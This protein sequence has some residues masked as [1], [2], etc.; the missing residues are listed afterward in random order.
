MSI[1]FHEK[2]KT[3]HLTNGQ[4]SYIFKVVKSGE[5]GQLYFGKALRDRE[6][7]DTLLEFASRS[8][9]V[10]PYDE[11]MSYSRDYI[12]QEYPC[13][14]TGDMQYPAFEIKQEN[15]SHI[16]NF[17]YKEHKIYA[18]KPSL[19][20]LPATYVEDDSEAT[21]IEITLEDEVINTEIILTYTIYE[22]LPVIA[23]NTKF[24]HKGEESIVLDRAMSMSLDLP[25]MDY[26]MI[27]LTGAWARERHIKTR[28]LDHGVTSIY[29]LRGCSSHNYNPFLALK[30]ENTTE[31]SGEV[32]GMSLVYSGNFLAQVDVD[33]YDVTRWMIGIHPDGFSWKLN[34]GESFQTPEAVLVYSNEGLNGMSQTFHTLYRS[35]LAKGEWR[36]KARPILIN[37]WEGTYFDFTEEKILEMARQSKELGIELF[38]LDDGWFGKRNDDLRGLGDWYPNLEKLPE[39]ITGLAKKVEEIGLKFGLWFEP[40]MVNEDSDLYRAHPDYALKTPNRKMSYGRHQFVLDFSREEVVDCIYHMMEKVLE[41]API[42]YIKWDMNRCMSEVYS[43]ALPAD[44]QG[45]VFHKYILGVY[46]LYDKLTK[47][48]PYILFES[49]ASGGAR[50]DPGLLHYAPQCWTSDN[51]DAV[52]RMK[53]QYGTS[54]VYPVSSMGAHVSAVPNHQVFRNTP[55]ST[56]ANMAYF[57]TFGYELDVT[58]MPQEEKEIVKGQIAFMKEHRQLLQF[59]TFYRLKSPFEGNV[60]AWMVVSEDKKEAIVGYYRVLQTVNAPFERVKLDGL[61]ANLS[62][63]VSILEKDIY[64]DELMLAGLKTTDEFDP[65]FGFMGINGIELGDYHSKIYLLK[66]NEN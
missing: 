28:K 44:E 31:F 24:I 29:S 37:N 62:Y 50:F 13:Y 60:M 10:C 5:L 23:R 38:V 3:F 27:E 57:G 52:E 43:A 17:I 15:G 48:F 26:E 65:S 21:T 9:T 66:A 22:N 30:R 36:D 54:L 4:I 59:G 64:G 61:D 12:K 42:S 46:R 19:E 53:I 56:R 25:D 14:G 33:T 16:T 35:R 47:K 49:C 7:F 8:M 32:M 55:I 63:H 40:E 1:L 18:G 58:K 2:S 6:D 20:G 11:D 45:K 51:S 34:Q 39:G 41:E